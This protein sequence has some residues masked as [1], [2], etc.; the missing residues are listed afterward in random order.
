MFYNSLYKRQFLQSLERENEIRVYTALFNNSSKVEQQF[1]TDLYNFTTSE[2]EILLYNIYSSSKNTLLTYLTFA[3]KYTD[4][5]IERGD[6]LSNI[7]L[8]RMFTYDKIDKFVYKHKQKFFTY[9]K[10]LLHVSSFYNASDRALVSAIFHGISG[11]AYS[12]LI[13]LTIDD[14]KEARS[15]PTHVAGDEQYYK[16][17]LLNDKKGETI[18]RY[19]EVPEVLLDDMEKSYRATIYYTKNGD[20]SS[21]R[22]AKDII[23]GNHIFRNVEFTDTTTEQIDKQV[24]YRRMKVLQDLTNNYISS[25][26]NVIDS[27]IL[28]YMY[29]LS[30]NGKLDYMKIE[31]VMRRY[32]KHIYEKSLPYTIARFIKQYQDALQ[33][34][35]G[36]V[37]VNKP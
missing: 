12:E 3:K 36:V 16:L 22:P 14:I 28:H 27:G 26:T 1:D 2:I 6:R 24:V 32:S 30:E 8:F 35:Y 17:R 4:Y 29:L 37:I 7:N 21:R 20:P 15:N 10:F 25:V 18:E 13:N 11:A 33:D 5:A 9:E 34:L 31:K 19:I 23:G